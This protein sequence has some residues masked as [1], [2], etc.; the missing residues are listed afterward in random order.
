MRRVRGK[1]DAKVAQGRCRAAFIIGPSMPLP[2]HQC[3]IY[4]GSPSRH[5]KALASA[6]CEK[7][8]QGH[9]CLYL[10]SPPM[11]A[12]MRSYL[13]AAGA[14]VE[15][16]IAKGSLVLFSDR[17]YLVDGHFE[18]ERMIQALEDVLT[19]AMRDGYVGL[20]AT[21]DMTWEMGDDKDFM[22]LLEYEWRLEEFFH[23]HPEI[24]GVCQY[25]ASTLPRE[26]MKQG[27]LAHPTLFVNE[28]LS[29]LNPSYL[30]RDAYTAQM[31]RNPKLD[32]TL[33]RL[34][35]PQGLE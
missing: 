12:G 3:L 32:S 28:T 21:G 30:R 5:L 26:T 15:Q 25:Y 13:A 4:D 7:L 9:R 8:R 20:W 29:L 14:D 6:L 18:P 33:T 11:V 22:K 19:Q 31:E 35:E 23:Q 1:P 2:R 16:E 10:N 17:N 34:L 27:L 24:G